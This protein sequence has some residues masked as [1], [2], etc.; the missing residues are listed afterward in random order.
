MS[1][2]VLNGNKAEAAAAAAKL[3]SKLGRRAVGERGSEIGD[4]SARV[5]T[6]TIGYNLDSKWVPRKRGTFALPPKQGNTCMPSLLR[7]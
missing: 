4:D 6:L 3:E 7:Q 2:Q 5:R 1:T